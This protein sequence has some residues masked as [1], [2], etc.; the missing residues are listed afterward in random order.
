QGRGFAVVADEV[1]TLASRTQDSTQ[2]IEKIINSLQNKTKNIVELMAECLVQGQESEKQASAAGKLLTAINNDVSSINDMNTAIAV[3]IE[4][5]S[6]VAS[7]VNKHVVSIRDVAEQ[8][9]ESVTKTQLM[10][11]ELSN[12]SNILRKELDRFII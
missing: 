7:E 9:G 5:Q 2:E 11:K 6:Q 8:S 3:S 10:S 12:Q 1:R 4:E